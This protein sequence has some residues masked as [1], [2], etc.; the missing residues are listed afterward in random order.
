MKKIMLPILC[1]AVLAAL[2]SPITFG[3]GERVDL[4]MRRAIYVTGKKSVIDLKNDSYVA[5]GE[6]KRFRKAQAASC[7]QDKCTFNLGIIAT[8]TGGGALST[9]GLFSGKFGLVGNGIVFSA[10]N[11]SRQQV[12]P[13]ELAVGSNTVKFEIDP[14]KKTAETDENNNSF[15][16]TII[17]E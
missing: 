3:S 14:Y 17:V 13:V 9:Y 2:I 4:S 7:A 6:T 5:A 11:I 16:V 15:T 1:T 12:L 8:R 10:G